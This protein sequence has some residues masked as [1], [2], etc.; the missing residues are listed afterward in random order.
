MPTMTEPRRDEQRWRAVLRR[1]LGKCPAFVYAVRTTGVFCRP[2][3]ASRTPLR[4]NVR[5]FD[6]PAAALMAGYR[7]C[8]RCR[9]D[10]AVFI[11]PH[12]DAIR[13]A[14]ERIL[15]SVN[16]PSLAA[17]AEG[18]ALNPSRFRAIFKQ[19]LG[20]TPKQFAHAARRSRLQ[21]KLP[22]SASVTQAIYQAGFNTPSR[23]Y[24]NVD[25]LLGMPPAAY[26]Q[27][28]VKQHIRYATGD[29]YPGRLLVAVTQRGLC[30]IELGD[31]DQELVQQL[32]RH[33]KA[34]QLAH[35]P[36]LADILA[37]VVAFIEA[38][39][40]SLNL[41]LDIQGTVFQQR[42]WQSLQTIP[43]GETRSYRELA[44]LVGQ[45][46]AVRAVASANARNKLAIVV[47][48]HRVIGSDGKLHGYRWGVKRKAA[49][50]KREKNA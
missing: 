37:R 45:P 1:D 13:R 3:C 32:R 43:A 20:V 26:R 36:S 22:Q 23:V 29:C 24:E 27:H 8:K 19:T 47:P 12:A 14:C 11:G 18:T 9:P 30:A 35:D 50:L 2:G 42:V 34:A 10:Q 15:R 39:A 44:E 40:Q 38:P 4:Q 17:L 25:R 5:F 21:A 16:E 6:T 28:G 46:S 33:F 31:R 48:C 49:I 7:A 41:P